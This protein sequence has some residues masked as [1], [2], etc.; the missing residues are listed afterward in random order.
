VVRK[1]ELKNN[2]FGFRFGGRSFRERKAFFLNYEDGASRE[3]HLY[4]RRPTD[5]LR[6]HSAVRDASA[7][8]P[9]ICNFDSLRTGNQSAI[10][11]ELAWLHISFVRRL[12]QG[13]DQRREMG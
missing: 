8:P 12:P 5:F 2:R 6:G 7:S 4:A 3:A 9:T 10:R 1:L 11:A 13:T